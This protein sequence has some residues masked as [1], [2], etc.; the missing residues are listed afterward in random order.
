[1]NTSLYIGIAFA[2]VSG[3]LL[4]SQY[5]KVETFSSYGIQKPNWDQMGLDG[6]DCD[7]A[8]E[9]CKLTC[10]KSI[11]YKKYYTD[12]KSCMQ[13]CLQQDVYCHNPSLV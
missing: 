3:Y 1:M 6:L 7:I 2:I 13:S 10:E 8:L 11:Y 12:D 9:N 4:G 5:G